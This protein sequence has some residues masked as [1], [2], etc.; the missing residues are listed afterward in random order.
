[1][2]ATQ[3]RGGRWYAKTGRNTCRS[4]R[5]CAPASWPEPRTWGR[6]LPNWGTAG[7]VCGLRPACRAMLLS[8][9]PS[10]AEPITGRRTLRPVCVARQGGA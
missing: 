6:C 1:M 4:K 9:S 10:P 8:A 3:S 5:G 7:G 2:R